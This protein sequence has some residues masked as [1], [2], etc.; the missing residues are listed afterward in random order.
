MSGGSLEAS[1]SGF[2]IYV[3]SSGNGTF[4]QSGG[5]V[6]LGDGAVNIASNSSGT[7]AYNLSGGSLSA[8]AIN[9]HDTFSMTGGSLAS[10]VIFYNHGRFSY[11]DGVFGG[12]LHLYDDG[13]MTIAADTG[14]TVEGGMVN[15]D[16]FS[17]YS[18]RALNVNGSGLENKGVITLAGGTLGGSGQ[19]V[20]KGR[21][22]ARGLIE[23][24]GGFT[25]EGLFEQIGDLTMDNSGGFTNNMFMKLGEND[26][27]TL[28]SAMANSGTI[29]LFDTIVNG[30]AQLTNDVG[31]VI[32]GDGLITTA[33]SNA[34]SLMVTGSTGISRDFTNTGKIELNDEAASLRGGAITNQ[35]TIHGRG[36]V[37]NDIANSGTIEAL[38]GAL[39]LAGQVTNGSAGRM[40]AP[41]GGKILVSR[42]LAANDG[43][44]SLQGGIFDNNGQAMTNNSQISGYGT[45]RTGGLTNAADI[46]LAGGSSTVD[47]TVTNSSGAAIEIAHGH[48]TFNDDV[49]NN[50]QFKTTDASVSFAGGFTNN[51][52]YFSDPSVNTFRNLSVGENGVLIGLEEGDTF[53]IMGDFW[54]AS[55]NRQGWNTMMALLE[56]IGDGT[57]QMSLASSDLGAAVDSYLNNFAWGCMDLTGE[58]IQ[59]S[60]GNSEPGGAFYVGG[61]LGAD[62]QNGGVYNIYGNGFNIYYLAG[63]E[64]NAYLGGLTYDL[65]EGGK[66]IAVAGDAMPTP[67][68]G[69]VWLLGSGI[70]LL[71]A[72]RRFS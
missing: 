24:S 38:N 34:G 10:G 59:L 9:N 23:G 55:T 61:L 53:R 16:D 45:L 21:M 41:A 50:G 15:E 48:A 8:S 67:I 14:L 47:G 28:E 30:T 33:F 54:N 29:T 12:T 58:V 43:R 44:I 7:G 25:N 70:A 39:S 31:G 5:T 32:R 63:L 71:A 3:G 49:T 57:H 36:Q 40:S 27:L 6:D 51:G 4:D 42:G 19:L 13:Y 66:L 62:I 35:G 52:S 20:N 68:P 37:A 72:R 17:I 65:R 2:H 18:G 22:Y 60:D 46:L 69:A 26:F 56:F 11:T 1:D 64:E